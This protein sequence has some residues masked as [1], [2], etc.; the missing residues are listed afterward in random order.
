MR[1]SN[2]LLWCL[3]LFAISAAESRQPNILF[4]AV[5]D[6]K[7]TLGCYGDTTAQT[8]EIDRLASRGTVFTNAQCQWPVCGPSRASL[9]TSLY[10]EA[11]GVMDLK[12]DM[13][14]KNPDVVSLTQ[15]FKDNGYLTLGTG[16]IYDPRCVD[17]KT[18]MDRPSWS[19]PFHHQNLR[20]VKYN[21]VKKVVLAP[22]VKDADLMDGQIARKGVRLL[23]ELAAAD[24]EQ[25]FFLAVGFKKPHLPFIAPKKY[26]D[27]YQRAELPLA[28]HAGG[29]ENDSGY[30]LH[31]SPEYRGYDGSPK[32]GPISEAYQREALHGYYAC[33]SF[34]DAQVGLLIGELDRLGLAD[35]TAIVL[36]GDHGFHLGDHSM[37]GKHSALE[38][39]A[40]VPLI[41]V[42]PGGAD[43]KGKTSPT[44]IELVDIYPTLCEW[45]GIEVPEGIAGRS[46]VPFFDGDQTAIREGA[47]TV[48]KKK[49]SMGYSFRTE[50]YRYNE[51]L[52]KFGKT[53]ATDLFD[54]QID[55][56]ETTN[57]AADP[58]YA[59]VIARLSQSMREQGVGCERLLGEVN[60]K[61][62]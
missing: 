25:P 62:K 11:V 56:L 38:Q 53:V 7:P 31:D 45:A 16:K 14:N 28:A 8:P 30:L 15:H 54:Y 21:D 5:D 49:G 39:A 6:L 32:T 26:W 34:I 37:W 3:L 19:Q 12:T 13:R 33:T 50:R 60:C 47:L 10:P 57:R 55:P 51:W 27:L 46:F 4:I 59:E 52:N 29:I 2:V 35:D 61:S 48:F 36:W 43:V 22:D 41:M 17:S 1:V 24:G 44:P 18:A 20:E 42:P 9:M 23:Q 40:R 58:E